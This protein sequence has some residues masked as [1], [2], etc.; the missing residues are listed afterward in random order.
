[1]CI[2]GV[3]FGFGVLR[4]SAVAI[5]TRPIPV[6]RCRPGRSNSVGGRLRSSFSDLLRNRRVFADG[7]LSGNESQLI[8]DD[9]WSAVDRPESPCAEVFCSA[10]DKRL[11]L[12]FDRIRSSKAV[13]SATALTI[14]VAIRC[15]H[16]R[17]DFA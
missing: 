14:L 10:I 7:R 1:M 4:P 6:M 3:N 9:E 12:S 17:T 8:N 16:S 5:A 13:T 11:L 15:R 2:H